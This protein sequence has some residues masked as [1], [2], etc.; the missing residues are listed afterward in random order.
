MRLIIII[1][2]ILE[3]HDLYKDTL[4]CLSS[5]ILEYVK[6]LKELKDDESLLFCHCKCIYIY[7]YCVC[8]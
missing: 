3:Y 4:I 1:T 7:I 5:H 6:E 8:A 2:Y